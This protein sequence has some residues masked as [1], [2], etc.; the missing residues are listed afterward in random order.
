MLLTLINGWQVAQWAISLSYRLQPRLRP[1]NGAG[2]KQTYPDATVLLSVIVM[3][4]WRKGYESFSGWLGRNS[5]LAANLGYTLY[6]EQGQ[7]QTISS[8]HLS[9][10]ARHLGFWPFLFFFIALVWQ[11]IRLGAITG[12]DVILDASVLKAWYHHDREAGWSYPTRWRGSIFGYKIHTL[13]CR[14]QV[15][16]VFLWITPANAAD[17]P[18]AVPLLAAALVLYGFQIQIV[19][20]DAA[21]F[22]QENPPFHLSPPPRHP[23]R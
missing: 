21:Y 7:L 23:L 14:Q 2:R 13:L 18:G 3:R 9:R 5:T 22:N 20:A 12:R 6:N 10:R 19:R 17:G 4:V 16:P 15:L 1:S 11:L 8:S